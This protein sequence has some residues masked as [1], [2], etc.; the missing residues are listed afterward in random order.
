MVIMHHQP[1]SPGIIVPDHDAVPDVESLSSPEF[2]GPRLC[3]AL[4]PSAQGAGRRSLGPSPDS[5][6]NSSEENF[7][8]ITST[9]NH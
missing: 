7:T 6:P 9:Q 8:D 4:P 3:R 5:K 1:L 2:L